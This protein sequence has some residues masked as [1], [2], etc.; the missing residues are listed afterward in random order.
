MALSNQ[1]GCTG[2]ALSRRHTGET[3]KLIN[4]YFPHWFPQHYHAF[5]EREQYLPVDQHLLIALLA[6]RPVLVLSGSDDLWSDPEGEFEGGVH[7]NPVFGLFDQPGLP[8]ASMPA[9]N[10]PNQ[11]GRIGYH[12]RTGGHDLSEYDWQCYLDYADRW[13]VDVAHGQ[14]IT[15]T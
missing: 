9:P 12:I 3:V 5:D 8:A 11:D 7:A 4:Y 15:K 14:D 2:A 10:R 1:S 13:M 6:P